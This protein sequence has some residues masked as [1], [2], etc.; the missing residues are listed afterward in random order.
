V[1]IG[2]LALGAR[3]FAG[4]DIARFRADFDVCPRTGAQVVHPS[5][6]HIST[7]EG[8]VDH[9]LGFGVKVPRRIDALFS[10]H[11]TGDVQQQ[12]PVFRAASA[13]RRR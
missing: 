13:V 1:G 7:G 5:W 2:G 8:P 12:I 6:V 11:R 10:G 9:E 3:Q 4:P